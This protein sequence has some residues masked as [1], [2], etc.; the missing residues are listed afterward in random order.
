MTAPSSQSAPYA[1]P[2]LI[3][4]PFTDRRAP[5]KLMESSRA[6]LVMRGLVPPSGEQS[7]QDLAAQLLEGRYCELRMLFY[8]GKDI[9]RW[10]DQCLEQT[11]RVPE[12]AEA[13][14]QME[15]FAELLVEHTPAVVSEKLQSWGVLDYRA[16][17][18]RALAM[19]TLLTDMPEQVLLG[20][21]FLR[22]Y[23]AY[24][25]AIYDVRFRQGSY[26]RTNVSQFAFQLYASG[27]YTRMLEEQWSR[28]EG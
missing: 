27:E 22:S 13:G 8:V 11:G 25:D 18:A 5:A 3:L 12:L 9:I 15:T 23:H 7:E 10:I 14:Y 1:L 21:E 6:S 17:F 26:V 28:Q 20:P 4:H 24:A 16:V 2:P 19:Q